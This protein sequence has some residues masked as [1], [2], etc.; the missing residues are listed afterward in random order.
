M[1]FV[2]LTCAFS[3]SKIFLTDKLTNGALV[4]PTPGLL[5]DEKNL[6]RMPGKIKWEASLP[7]ER[8]WSGCQM[9]ISVFMPVIY[10]H[11]PQN[12]GWCQHCRISS[13]Q[14]VLTTNLVKKPTFVF[15]FNAFLMF[16]L[17]VFARRWSV[18][19]AKWKNGK[20][21]MMEPEC[22]SV[23]RHYQANS[24]DIFFVFPMKMRF[25]RSQGKCC[26]LLKHWLI[27]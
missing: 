17:K 11:V 3:R 2:Y 6:T 19:I 26:S 18:K 16:S 24:I 5:Q 22:M 21:Y 10:F 20:E 15:K 8:L 13:R 7:V 12:A 1:F 14:N 9:N 25:E 4:T 23:I 27:I